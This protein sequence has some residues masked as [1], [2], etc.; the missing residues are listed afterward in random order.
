[1]LIT[2]RDDDGRGLSF[3]EI[4]DEV[5]TFLFEGAH[6][7]IKQSSHCVCAGQ[8]RE[9]ATRV[10]NCFIAT[11][12]KLSSSSLLLS[13]LESV[14]YNYC[15]C[16]CICMVM[17]C[18]SAVPGHDTTASGISWTLYSLAQS[19]ECQV[20]CQQEVDQVLQ[21][22]DTDELSWLVNIGNISTAVMHLCYT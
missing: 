17:L 16:T 7:F 13:Q 15:I 22:R 4:R 6:V 21:G 8:S 14:D 10:K 18:V 20:K 9:L 2:A 19:S 3:R 12:V 11:T 5:D 1:M